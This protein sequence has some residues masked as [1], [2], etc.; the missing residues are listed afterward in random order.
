MTLEEKLKLTGLYDEITMYGVTHHPNPSVERH[1]RVHYF[2][3]DLCEHMARYM[4]NSQ[5]RS[6][7]DIAKVVE[8]QLA[9]NMHW[10][11][12]SSWA[13]YY[14]QWIDEGT[15]TFYGHLFVNER[16]VSLDYEVIRKKNYISS[17][18]YEP[19]DFKDRFS[20]TKLENGVSY[21][22][23]NTEAYGYGE[24]TLRLVV[25]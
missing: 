24:R 22:S 5:I 6:T 7:A 9:Y 15:K 8:T 23:F 25:H 4:F 14:K 2:I 3:Q 20:Q 11:S 17:T 12:V 18:P 13:R 10:N 16:A 19:T 21:V 1:T